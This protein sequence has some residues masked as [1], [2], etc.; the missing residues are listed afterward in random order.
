M[1]GSARARLTTLALALLVPLAAVADDDREPP[2]AV[3]V[4]AAA[5]IAIVPLLAGGVAY[6]SS[7]DDGLR[8]TG[9]LVAMGGLVLAPAVGHL[10]LREY[11]RAA[12]FTALPLAAFL[13][14]VIVLELDPQVTTFGSPETRV[15]FGVALTAATL[16]AAVGLADLFAASDRWRARHRGA[17]VSF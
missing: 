1:L 5:G 12:I 16:G 3:A 7:N 9:M 4:G 6:G 15:T 8:R 10:A 13:T 17:T 2:T 11:K 14:N